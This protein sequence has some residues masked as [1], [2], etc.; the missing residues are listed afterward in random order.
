MLNQD[1]L[2]TARMHLDAVKAFGFYA[3]GAFVVFMLGLV[4]MAFLASR[5]EAVEIE[6]LIIY[7]HTSDILRGPP[8]TDEAEPTT[9]YIGFGASIIFKKVE[10]DLSHGRKA[11]DC[12]YVRRSSPTTSRACFWE[13]GSQVTV[14]WYPWRKK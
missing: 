1:Q 2:N 13:S 6:P 10:L 14:R 9:D 7:S 5:A 12:N 8:F 3:L 11:R 4:I